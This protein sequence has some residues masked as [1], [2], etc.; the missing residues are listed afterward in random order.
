MNYL[1]FTFDFL[2]KYETILILSINS[3][4][5]SFIINFL[6]VLNPFERVGFLFFK[7]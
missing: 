5:L 3:V 1:D 4:T 6:V 7:L 2:Y